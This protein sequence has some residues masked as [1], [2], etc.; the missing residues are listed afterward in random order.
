MTALLSVPRAG[1]PTRKRLRILVRGAV[2]GVGFRPFVHRHA[3]ALGLAGWV[4]N[5]TEG[6]VIE[7]EGA[8]D[9]LCALI[10]SVRETPPPNASI[11][12]VE[13][14]E[15]AWRGENGFAVLPSNASG[16]RAV[17]VLPDLATCEDCLREL[18]DPADRRHRYPFINCTQ[19]GPRYSII[20]DLP[21]DRAR[22][23]MRH[24]AM[25][26]ACRT[27]Y[28]DP[29][30]RR[31]HA[32]P[33]ACPDCGPRLALWDAGGGVLA[34]DNDALLAAADALRAGWTVAVKGLGGFHLF[35]DARNEAA[36]RRLR[37]AK[38]REEKPFAVMFP[39]LSAVRASCCLVPEEKALLVGPARPIVL[40]R[41][42]DGV[43]APSVAPENSRLGALL[44]YTP[45]HHLLVRELGFPVVAT[46]GNVT[47]EPIVTD[48]RDAPSRLASIA[49]QFLVHD[50]PIVRPVDDSVA[51][52]VCDKPQ[53]LR[54]A[55]GYAPAPILSGNLPDG[56]LAFGGHLKATIGMTVGDS[57]V[58]SQ[59]LGDLD[60]VSAR[61]GYGRALD[62]IVRLHAARPRIAVCDAHP[63]YASSH[64]AGAMELPMLRVQHHVAHVTACM[65]E[66]TLD[67]P[68]LGVAWDGTGFGPD[69]TVWG[70]EFLLVMEAGWRRVAHLRSF[71]LPGGDAVARD[72]RRA[73]IGLLFA[74][75]GDE[76]FDM[77]DLEP[78]ASFTPAERD[79]LRTML[80]RGINTPVTT[81]AGRLFDAFAALCGLRQRSSYEGQAA[82]ALEWA[83]EGR[84]TGRA[85]EL[86]LIDVENAA[87]VV[88]WEPALSAALADLRAGQSAGASSE[89]LHNGLASAIASVASYVGE[90]R[91]VL[92][93]GCFQNGR[94]TE[95]TVRALARA[96]REP[97]WHC[98]VPPNDGGIA[99]GQAVWAAW[100]ETKEGLPCA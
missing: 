22:T 29:A 61:V 99:V 30:H 76:T 51:H 7:A 6:V 94:L 28:E 90:R 15:V 18:F 84:A 60:T 43:V 5:T 68:V 14:H 62:D 78:V 98:R 33:N 16:V 81:S 91:I 32:E 42:A 69:G 20:E 55:R 46:S 74:A 2:Q 1:T 86:P 66:H 10:E 71:Y 13:M 73:A 67:P 56:I 100:Y 58:L 87:V 57:L 83:A 27:E 9:K 72:P 64:T 47:D 40:L 65:A 93:G 70:G 38:R 31:F 88:D 97:Y 17:Q 45:L 39:T 82:A 19:C 54:R 59:H 36:V 89:A 4:G 34:R 12:A 52:L 53:L 26:A 25:C 11:T 85:Y 23:A 75:Y 8:Q 50:R 3:T 48:E 79:V 35:V 21:Y 80:N 44:P 37:V 24:F 49:D 92:S 96:G 41:R 95:A 77:T 63:D